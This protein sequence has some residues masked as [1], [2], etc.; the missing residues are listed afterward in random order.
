MKISIPLGLK[1]VSFL[2]PF[3]CS[4]PSSDTDLNPV[5]SVENADVDHASISAAQKVNQFLEAHLQQEQLKPNQTISDEVFVRRV[6][7]GI[8][9]RIPTIAEFFNNKTATNQDYQPNRDSAVP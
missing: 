2:L 8:I 9:G 3:G 4:G 1:L 7:L 5:A 6:Y